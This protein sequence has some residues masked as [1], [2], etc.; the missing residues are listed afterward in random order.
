MSTPSDSGS[1]VL[2]AIKELERRLFSAQAKR[3]WSSGLYSGD[4]IE[5]SQ[6]LHLV[7]SSS[8]Q[9]QRVASHS[10]P[11]DDDLQSDAT[12]PGRPGPK[13]KKLQ[14]LRENET[15]SEVDVGPSNQLR[16][17]EVD[18]DSHFG[19]FKLDCHHR[20]RNLAQVEVITLDDDD[21]DG[22]N[23]DDDVQLAGYF[24][25]DECI[26]GPPGPKR[27]KLQRL[28]FPSSPE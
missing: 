5:A 23:S 19:A 8:L 25:A 9:Q 7:P 20:Q 2:T 11:C 4:T 18:S 10:A 15:N 24:V 6:C 1:A 3:D 26:P 17:E 22:D 13:S 16:G 12:M 14:W 27:V 28:G 21:E